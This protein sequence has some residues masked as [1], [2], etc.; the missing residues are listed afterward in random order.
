[1]DE[2]TLFNFGKCID[3]GKFQH[4]A[5]GVKDFPWKG[6]NLGHVTVL[7]ILTPSMFLEWTKLRS[8]NLTRRST[9]ACPTPRIKNFQPKGAWY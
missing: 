6:R 9:T 8:L 7:K 1:M 4:R 2:A 5:A 3:C